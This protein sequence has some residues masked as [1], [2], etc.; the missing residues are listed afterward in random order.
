MSKSFVISLAMQMNNQQEE[1]KRATN[2]DPVII[3]EKALA[4]CANVATIY[5]INVRQL[6]GNLQKLFE[7]ISNLFSPVHDMKCQTKVLLTSL[8]KVNRMN[9]LLSR[10]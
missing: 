5:P 3:A 10:R 4:V 9:R 7:I 8:D 2:V 1:M 6:K